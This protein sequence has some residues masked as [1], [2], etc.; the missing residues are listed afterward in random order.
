[1]AAQ[2]LIDSSCRIDDPAYQSLMKVIAADESRPSDTLSDVSTSGNPLPIDLVDQAGASWTD[3]PPRSTTPTLV[4]RQVATLGTIE[5]ANKVVLQQIGDAGG[6]ATTEATL[7]R[8][9]IRPA[10][11]LADQSIPDGAADAHPI[12]YWATQLASGSRWV[13]M[14]AVTELGRRGDSEALVVLEKHLEIET[15]AEVVAKIQQRLSP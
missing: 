9:R 6:S 15:D 4:Q 14:Q 1:H 11:T 7:L 10:R 5:N 12:S 13:R 2:N 8:P 3:W